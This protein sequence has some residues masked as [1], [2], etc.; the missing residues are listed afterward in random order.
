M[1]DAEP[2]YRVRSS[3]DCHE[4]AL[5]ESQ[6]LYVPYYAN[7]LPD[8]HRALVDVRRFGPGK[9]SVFEP[10]TKDMYDC[11]Q[12]WIEKRGIFPAYHASRGT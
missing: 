12:T 9:R 4:R 3:V 10:Y 2:R 1:E 11:T 5:R 8:R 6:I 7:A